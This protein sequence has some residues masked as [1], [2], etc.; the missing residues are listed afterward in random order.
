M[1]N[2][3]KWWYALVGYSAY[4]LS[5]LLNTLL[6]TL[7]ESQQ[8]NGDLTFNLGALFNLTMF[9]V[10]GII[11]LVLFRLFSK[12]NIS[13]FDFGIHLN[14]FTKIVLIGSCCGLLFF[15][16]SEL[17]EANSKSLREAS[18][19]VAN[20]FNIGK[21]LINDCLLI[22]SVGLFAPVVEEIIFR[23][24][25][26]N[27]IYQSLK[28]KKLLPNW[29]VLAVSLLVSTFLFVYSHG[30]GGQEAQLGMLAMLGLFTG[31]VMYKTNSL[32]G[33]I[34]VH[35]VNNNFVFIYMVYKEIGLTSTYRIQ[36]IFASVFCLLLCIPLG[37]LFGKLLPQL[38]MN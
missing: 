35:A 5:F 7:V 29:V 15:I 1:Q 26:F 4:I 31:I 10:G 25:I 24:A 3:F 6:A 8:S 11:C 2:K 22:L 37:L 36:L 12:G 19:H 33:A 13:R 34:L 23:G 18:A 20:D 30:G 14:K 32:F 38:K 21:N 9:I 16:F 28:T 27:S 17:I